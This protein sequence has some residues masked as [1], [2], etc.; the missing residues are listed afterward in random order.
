MNFVPLETAQVFM[1][2]ILITSN[3]ADAARNFKLP[4][5][6]GSI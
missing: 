1:F 2:R 4:V 6:L 3:N 5:T